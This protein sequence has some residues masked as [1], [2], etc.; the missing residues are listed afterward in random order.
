MG[1]GVAPEGRSSNEARLLKGFWGL[2]GEGVEAEE[3]SGGGAGKEG[4]VS[5]VWEF[6]AWEGLKWEGGGRDAGR[7]RKDGH[8][9]DEEEAGGGDGRGRSMGDVK[10]TPVDGR[11]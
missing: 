5:L 11:K 9:G 8:A 10:S 3:E 4:L 1:L 7:E 6:E 2:T